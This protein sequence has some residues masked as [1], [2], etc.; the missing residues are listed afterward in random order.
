MGEVWRAEHESLARPAAVKLLRAEANDQ[1]G[2]QERFEREAR[3]IA[4][5]RHPNIIQLFDFGKMDQDYY[6]VMEYIDG[7][8]LAARIKREPVPFE[9]A[10]HVLREIGAALDYAHAQGIVHRDVKPSNIMLR[11]TG[12]AIL[13]DFGIAKSNVDGGLTKAGGI[14]GT[15]HYMAPE[16]I[17]GAK[18]V[19]G[20]ADIYAL[21]VVAFEVLTGTLPFSGDNPG[22]V[23]M[24]HL[25]RPIPDPRSIR[26][27]L[28]AW[29][30]AALQRAL[31]KK[32]EDRFATA[33]EF[34]AA[35]AS[36]SKENGMP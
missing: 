26:A 5:L 21:G 32:P 8:S 27:T 18:D 2:L 20:R 12:E 3:T 19:D 28:P 24:G 11:N 36:D 14:V 15:L 4:A 33:A 13:M 16:Q 9:N 6:M 25:Q 22:V 1:A 31:A 23:L 7:E 35:L 34:V 29:V 10:V 17:M 30:M